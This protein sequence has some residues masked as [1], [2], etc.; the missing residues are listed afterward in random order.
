MNQLTL[1]TE[2]LQLVLQST[3]EVLS[4]IEALSPTDR[5]HVSQ[6]WLERV[7]ASEQPNHWTHGFSMIDLASGNVVGSCAFKGPP[8]PEGIVEIA[9]GVNPDYGRRGY[10]TEAARALID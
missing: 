9:Y 5:T 8:D 4:Q 6:E 7:R 10:A 1:K 2:R 3:E